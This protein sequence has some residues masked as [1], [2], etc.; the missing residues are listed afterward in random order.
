MRWF[1]E[2][3]SAFHGNGHE[4]YHTKEAKTAFAD[5]LLKIADKCFYAPY[6]LVLSVSFL[7]GSNFQI[8]ITVLI[9]FLFLVAATMLRHEALSIID[10]IND[11]NG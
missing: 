5:S 8:F 4:P 3:K 9:S 1:Q 6:V 7:K 11:T 2:F 10:E